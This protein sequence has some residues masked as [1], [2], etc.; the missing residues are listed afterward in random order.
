MVSTLLTRKAGMGERQRTA[1]ARRLFRKIDTNGDGSLTVQEVI[2][3]TLDNYRGDSAEEAAAIRKAF[4]GF[5]AADV[6]K[7]GSLDEAEFVQYYVKSQA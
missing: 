7:S 5:I 3:Y 2:D 4:D 1:E 6:D